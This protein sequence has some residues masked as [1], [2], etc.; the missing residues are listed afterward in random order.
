MSKQSI[1]TVLLLPSIKIGLKTL[2]G[3]KRI[4]SGMILKKFFF[5]TFYVVFSEELFNNFSH[6]EA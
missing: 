5:R 1:F 3:L 4:S 2:M 6:T